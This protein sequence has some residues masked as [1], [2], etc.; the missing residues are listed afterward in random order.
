MLPYREISFDY[1]ERCRIPP[2]MRS[3]L[4]QKYVIIF[5]YIY[6]RIIHHNTDKQN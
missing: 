6:E 5:P 3:Q 1:V 4:S 2:S